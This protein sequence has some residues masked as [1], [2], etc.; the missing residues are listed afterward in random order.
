MWL[1]LTTALGTDFLNELLLQNDIPEDSST[2]TVLHSLAAAPLE[3]PSN[4]FDTILTTEFH[5]IEPTSFLISNRTGASLKDID[6]GYKAAYSA[7]QQPVRKYEQYSATLSTF[8]NVAIFCLFDVLFLLRVASTFFVRLL[9]N[10][11]KSTDQNGRWTL[12][13]TTSWSVASNC[14][15]VSSALSFQ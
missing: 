3:A 11:L 9:S 13:R 10:I 4:E 8:K 5:H 14:R 12:R 6:L 2:E 15:T 7:P 1:Q